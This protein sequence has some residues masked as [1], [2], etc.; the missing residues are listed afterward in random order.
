MQA[1]YNGGDDHLRCSNALRQQT[2]IDGP[3]TRSTE[4]VLGCNGGAHFVTDDMLPQMH[5]QATDKRVGCH[6]AATCHA[7]SR[8]PLCRQQPVTTLDVQQDAVFSTI[9]T[10]HL[11]KASIHRRGIR[12]CR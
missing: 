11:L 4:V 1:S 7:A 5:G 2:P 9:V 6:L 10:G 8:Q 12:M 3:V